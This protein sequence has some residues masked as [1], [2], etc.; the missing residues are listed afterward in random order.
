[1]KSKVPKSHSHPKDHYMHEISSS[2]QKILLVE[3][4]IV[5]QKVAQS[6][7][8]KLGFSI[9]RSSVLEYEEHM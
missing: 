3:D 2:D 8:Q 4:N 6:M 5:N 7:L 1:V 9:D